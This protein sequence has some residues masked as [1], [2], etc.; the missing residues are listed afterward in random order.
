[1]PTFKELGLKQELLDAVEKLGFTQPT[2][3]QELAIPTILESQRDLIALAQTGTG[4]TGAFG[5]PSL[6]QIDTNSDDV[7]VLVLSPTRELAIQIAR[8][9]KDFAKYQKAV[10]TV[11]VYGGANIST[12]IKALRN[13]C[14]VVIGTP[15]RMLDLINRKQLDVRNVRTLVLDEADEMLNMGFQDDLDAI[16]KDTPKEKQTLLFSATMPKGIAKIAKKYMNNP[17]EIEVG[18]RNAGAKNV[19][20]H[21]YM[22][23]AKNRFEALKRVTDMNPDIYGIIFCRTRRETAEIASKLNKDGYDV[24]LLNGDLSQAQR[25]D[26]MDRFRTKDLQLLV[27]TDVAARGLDVNELTHVINYNLPDDLE[28]YIHRSGRTGRAGNSGISISI[29]HTRETGRIRALE[30]MSGKDFI[31]KEVPS[32]EEICGIRM[33]NLIDTVKETKV[34]EEQMAKFLPEALEKLADLERDDLIK[35][36]LAVE[37]NQ[38]LEYYSNS[39]DLNASGGGDRRKGNNDRGSRNDRGGRSGGRDRGVTEAG[40]ERFFINVGRRDGLNPVRLMGLV[41]EQLNGSKPDFGKIDLQNNFS[42]FEVESGYES[43]LTNSV[44]GAKFEGRDVAVERAQ[45]EKKSN[46]G[47]GR[48]GGGKRKSNDGGFPKGKRK[49]GN[50]KRSRK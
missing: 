25:D 37:F 46:S 34:N 19:E 5:L 7:Q 2:K 50:R 18:E 38:F 32:G 20:H 4:K 45:D 8:D 15:G 26:V 41:N 21:Y 31:K 3:V 17:E 42:F 1:M 9:L 27:A 10:K 35:H 43:A 30:K 40:Y 24:D 14:Q 29:I 39:N 12:Q 48:S 16:L 22:V 23:H 36:F 13:G 6:H 49:T 44:T 47:G 11:A 33:L 28:V